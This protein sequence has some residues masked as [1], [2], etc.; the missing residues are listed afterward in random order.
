MKRL[1]CLVLVVLFFP[2]CALA[3]FETLRDVQM[4]FLKYIQS[5]PEVSV[6]LSG[7]V[8]EMTHPKDDLYML[9]IAVDEE[10]AISSVEYQRAY[11]V[12]VLWFGYGITELPFDVGDIVEIYGSLNPLYS[13]QIVPEIYIRTINGQ[14]VFD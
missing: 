12:G 2:V 6:H 3:E 8:I 14:S 10:R 5:V 7:E 9:K 4:F 1:L 13:S 11:F